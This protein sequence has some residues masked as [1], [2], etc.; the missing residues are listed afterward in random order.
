MEDLDLLENL[1]R[2]VMSSSLCALGGT[3]PNPVLTTLR[4]FR[5]EYEAHIKEQRC[6]GA[7]CV[8][9]ITHR[10]IAEDCTGCTLCDKACPADAITGEPKVAGSYVIHMDKCINCSMCV[11]VCKPDCIVVE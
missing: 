4:Y 5:E 1:S 8:A 3:A 11:E 6:P 9:L 7:K 10:V 2:Q